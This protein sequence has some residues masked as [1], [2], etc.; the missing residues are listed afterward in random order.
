MASACPSRQDRWRRPTASSFQRTV[1]KQICA[2]PLDT[3]LSPEADR[4]SCRERS[5]IA[6]RCGSPGLRRPFQSAVL[7]QK[8]FDRIA[9]S[10]KPL[11][12]PITPS[13]SSQSD[14]RQPS[15]I[16]SKNAAIVAGLSPS[17]KPKAN[18]VPLLKKSRSEG[19]CHSQSF[20]V[21]SRGIEGEKAIG[22]VWI[23]CVLSRMTNWT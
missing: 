6:L 17:D 3:V 7:G 19:I 18:L 9:V 12:P 15:G 1:P 16:C 11:S 4:P 14:C 5:Q 2:C 20:S 21:E 10:R 22:S 13:R 8:V 23:M